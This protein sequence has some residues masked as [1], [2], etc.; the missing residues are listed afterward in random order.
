MID[1]V[2][3]PSTTMVPCGSPASGADE[4]DED[5]GAKPPQH[6]DERGSR[7]VEADTF[8]LDSRAGQRRCCDHPER[9]RGD[10]AGDRQACRRPAAGRRATETV[11]PRRST[12]APKAASARSVWSRV[13]AGSTPRS[14]ARHGVRRAGPPTSPGRW[15]PPAGDAMACSG[16]PCTSAAGSRR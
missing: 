16:V 12:A 15:G 1:P 2:R 4:L 7:R 8:D 3:S 11:S 6:A 13:A 10:V 9:R 14:S 5:P